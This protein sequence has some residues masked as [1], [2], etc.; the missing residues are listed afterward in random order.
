[1]KNNLKKHDLMFF[2]IPDS[3]S[4]K[5][6]SLASFKNITKS[7]LIQKIIDKEFESMEAVQLR[8]PFAN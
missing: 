4:K 1:M 6:D 3:T 5:V 7:L 8:L 2:L